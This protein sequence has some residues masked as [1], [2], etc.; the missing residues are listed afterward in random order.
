MKDLGV[1]GYCNEEAIATLI[2]ISNGIVRSFR[3][4]DIHVMSY[5]PKESYKTSVSGENFRGHED[6]DQFYT[7][8]KSTSEKVTKK[9][10]KEKEIN[11]LRKTLDDAVNRQDFSAAAKA[12]DDLKSALNESKDISNE[13]EM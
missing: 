11:E 1:C 9:I 13:S 2:S 5:A 3:F 10:F 4:C 8:E 7:C 6:E 12:R